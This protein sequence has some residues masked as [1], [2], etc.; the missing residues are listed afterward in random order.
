[1]AAWT[2]ALCNRKVRLLGANGEV[3][4]WCTCSGLNPTLS[5]ADHEA[6]LLAVTLSFLLPLL[7]GAGL[8]W[9]CCRQPE[10]RLHQG[11]WGSRRD[12]TCSG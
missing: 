9:C 8:A 5:F 6:F 7:P 2:V 12:P 1:M 4:R 3:L 10:S 11:F